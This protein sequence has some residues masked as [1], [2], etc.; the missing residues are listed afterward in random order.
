M[1]IVIPED[2]TAAMSLE[3]LLLGFVFN[4]RD[5]GPVLIMPD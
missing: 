4:G 5:L 2:L 3:K 1:A